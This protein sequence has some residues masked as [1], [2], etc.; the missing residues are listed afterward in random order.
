MRF[1]VK[2]EANKTAKLS[3]LDTYNELLNIART[4]NKDLI[5]ESVYRDSYVDKDESR[6][7]VEDQLALSY[8][9]KCAYCER[10]TKADVEHYRPKKGVNEDKAHDGYYW[11]CY[12]WTNLIPACVKCN[13]DGGKHNQFPILGSRLYSPIFLLNQELDL[14]E[15]KILSIPL[16]KEKPFLLHPEKDNP[17]DFF[18]FELDPNGEG[19]RIKGVDIDNRGEKTIEICILNRQELRIEREENVINP[20]KIAIEC[21]YKLF[22]EGIYTMEQFVDQ[23]I[24]QIKILVN[25]SKNEKGTHTLLKKYIV[26]NINNFENIVVPF[27]PEKLQN[28]VLEAFKSK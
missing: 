15:N 3:S 26:A 1:V 23:I 5:K 8:Y 2:P 28:I 19:I 14:V 7:K 9:N 21:I 22:E 25:H 20:L 27:F 12:E 18:I 17:E 24:L 16:D 13:R 11:L 10:I 6:S 4:K